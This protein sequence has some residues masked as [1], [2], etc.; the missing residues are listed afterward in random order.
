MI[1]CVQWDIDFRELARRP[2]GP[3]YIFI[4]CFLSINTRSEF[5]ELINMLYISD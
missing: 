4:I 2:R 3:K 1:T 5:I